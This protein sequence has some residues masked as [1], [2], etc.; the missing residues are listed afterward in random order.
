[1][2]LVILAAGMGSRYGGLKQL[3]PL[4]PC[5]E[6]IIDYSVYDAIKAGFSEV[7]F[8]IKKEHEEDFKS[9]IACRIEKKVKISYAFQELFDI[10]KTIPF[11]SDRQKPWGTSHAL[12]SA[13]DI[14][15]GNFA[16]I[17]ADDF[18]GRDAF[19]SIADFFKNTSKTDELWHYCMAGYRLRK[20]ITENGHVSRGVCSADQNGKLTTIDELLKIEKHGDI[21]EYFNEDKDAWF[22]LDANSVV[23][24]NIW[25]FDDRFFDFIQQGFEQFLKSNIQNLSKKEY[26]LPLTVQGMINC[27]RGD[28][29]VLTCNDRWYGVTYKEDRSGVVNFLKECVENGIYPEN[30]WS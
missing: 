11:P 16:V 25:G 20:T 23:S 6:F 1:M 9:T 26:Y 17:N 12:L 13:R 10:P 15:K 2:T 24:M 21:I 3:D 5:G 19:I 30:L 28:V 8:I 4:G 18:Y 22:S 29:S 27:Q 7:C 14:V